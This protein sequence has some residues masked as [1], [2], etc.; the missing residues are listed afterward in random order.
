MRQPAQIGSPNN[1]LRATADP[2]ISAKS[3]AA[4]ATFAVFQQA[5]VI[6][7]ACRCGGIDSQA[8]EL[9]KVPI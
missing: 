4:I 7:V 8:H 6:N 5:T 2:M 3:V 1:R 9:T